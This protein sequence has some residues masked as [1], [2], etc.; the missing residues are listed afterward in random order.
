MAVLIVLSNRFVIAATASL[1]RNAEKLASFRAK[2]HL[3]ARL[4]IRRIRRARQAFVIPA[5]AARLKAAWPCAAMGLSK[6]EKNAMGR[7]RVFTMRTALIIARLAAVTMSCN[8]PKRTMTGIPRTA[9]V[10]TAIV[11]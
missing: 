5:A 7:A 6:A 1:R 3:V 10:V 11:I 9:T 8:L 2:R 4:S